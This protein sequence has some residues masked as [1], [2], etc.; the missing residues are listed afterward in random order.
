MPWTKYGGLIG[1]LY[2]HQWAC[3]P[4]RAFT[5]G[6]EL[7]WFT[8]ECLGGLMTHP[9]LSFQPIHVG[10]DQPSTRNKYSV[11]NV[12]YQLYATYMVTVA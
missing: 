8:Y 7:I 11:F 3:Y 4:D 2:I 12:V 10:V 9:E 6:E 1:A 5:K